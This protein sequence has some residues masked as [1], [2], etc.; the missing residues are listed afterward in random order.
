MLISTLVRFQKRKRPAK[1]HC[2]DFETLLPD[3]VEVEYLSFIISLADALLSHHP[4]TID[5]N[6]CF[7][8]TTITVEST[9]APLYLPQ[10]AVENLQRPKGLRVAFL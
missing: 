6:L 9:G 5:F 1:S 4:R 2:Q 8:G 7:D 10:E 3:A